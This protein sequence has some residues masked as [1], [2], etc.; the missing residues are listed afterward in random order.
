MPK[1]P[2]VRPK[3]RWEDD[4]LEEHDCTQLEECSTEQRQMEES[5]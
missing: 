5:S 3:I 1:R 2:I 4:V